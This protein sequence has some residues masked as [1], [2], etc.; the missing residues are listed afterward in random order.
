MLGEGLGGEMEEVVDEM[1]RDKLK[2]T[3]LDA[4]DGGGREVTCSTDPANR[5][6]VLVYSCF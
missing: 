1:G 6:F 3:L 4:A 5:E 2:W